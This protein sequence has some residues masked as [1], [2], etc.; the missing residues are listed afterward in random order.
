MA[1]GTDQRASWLLPELLDAVGACGVDTQNHCN[2]DDINA[3]SFYCGLHD[4]C[5]DPVKK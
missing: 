1:E 2:G 4:G 5:L 3:L